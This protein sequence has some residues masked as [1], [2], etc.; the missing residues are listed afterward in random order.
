MIRMPSFALWAIAWLLGIPSGARAETLARFDAGG[1]EI[2]LMT[3]ACGARGSK[4]QRAQKTAGGQRLAGCWAV[5]ARGNPVA[6]WSDGEV[7]ELDQ[8]RVRLA[9][10]FAAML[11][12]A[13]PPRAAP[14]DFPRPA[15]CR[16]ARFAHERLVCRD[17]ELAA[18]DLALAP[19]W[20]SYRTELK[21]NAVQQGRQK[22]DY[23]RRLKACGANKPCIARE[24]AAQMRLY[25][26]ALG[27]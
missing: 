14:A 22:S 3:E 23:F 2:L 26:N 19:L 4:L 27:R 21:L 17:K 7:Q 6:M 13:D 9:P 16:D 1:D 10:K 25:R 15:W 12:D 5:N 11:E 8:A 24:Q 20:R 18:A